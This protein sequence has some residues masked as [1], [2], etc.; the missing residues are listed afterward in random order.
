MFKYL[1]HKEMLK[2]SIREN[3]A[4]R[5]LNKELEDALLELAEIV[6]ENAEKLETEE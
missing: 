3:E 2:E 6:A 4:L 5:A 1:N